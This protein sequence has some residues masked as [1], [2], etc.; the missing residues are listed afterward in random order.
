M[1]SLESARKIENAFFDAERQKHVINDWGDLFFKTTSSQKLLHFFRKCS[2]QFLACQDDTSSCIMHGL[3]KSQQLSITTKAKCLK[4]LLDRGV[5]TDHLDDSKKGILDYLIEINDSGDC[6][7]ILLKHGENIQVSEK[8][9]LL[10]FN[11]RNQQKKGFKFLLAYA[12]KQNI[13]PH[14]TGISD[15]D[16]FLHKK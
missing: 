2:E 14:L 5:S 16:T 7:E 9:L 8:S 1:L 13:A 6:I 12:V 11:L 4:I 15:G 10:A 3:V